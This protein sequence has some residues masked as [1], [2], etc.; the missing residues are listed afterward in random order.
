ML[1]LSKLTDY[2]LVVL[3]HLT[4]ESPVC[5]RAT[6]D[7]AREVR[8]PQTTVAKVLKELTR[9]GLLTSTRGAHG[10]YALA[11]DPA[12]VTVVDVVEAIEGPL[13]LT[14]CSVAGHEVCDDLDT[15]HL[16]GHWPRINDAVLGA[17]RQV[18]L[19]DL[20]RPSSHLAA[21]ASAPVPSEVD[22]V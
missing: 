22:H 11:R 19:A 9:A 12:G 21:S 2:A 18:S 14:A 3:A 4:R 13:A 5:V 16:S 8:L 7:I 15:C 1:R 20:A 6:A 17:L 10:G